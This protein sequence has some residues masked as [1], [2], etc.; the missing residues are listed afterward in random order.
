MFELAVILI[1]IVLAVVIASFFLKELG[2]M[3]LDICKL[4]AWM[5]NYFSSKKHTQGNT[6]PYKTGSYRV[7]TTDK[8]PDYLPGWVSLFVIG[9]ALFLV[10]LVAVW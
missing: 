9:L 4:I 3:F 8:N 6:G 10:Y 7:E 5:L 1:I 2:N